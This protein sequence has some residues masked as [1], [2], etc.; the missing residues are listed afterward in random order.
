M[1]KQRSGAL[2]TV[3]NAEENRELTK[4]LKSLNISQSVWIAKK[5][6][7]GRFSRFFKTLH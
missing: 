5:V 6:I 2:A 1:C 7:T 4:F 3:F